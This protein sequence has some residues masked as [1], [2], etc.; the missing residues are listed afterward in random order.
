MFNPSNE[1]RFSLSVD[2]VENNLQVLSFKGQ[3]GITQ[4]YRFDVERVSENSAL[5]LQQLLHKQAFLALDP[6]GNGIHGLIYRV[7]QGGRSAR[8]CRCGGAPVAGM[9]GGAGAAPSPAR[10]VR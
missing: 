5:D 10:G 3:E 8:E 2:D 6:Q 4:P 7:A 9:Q 1:S